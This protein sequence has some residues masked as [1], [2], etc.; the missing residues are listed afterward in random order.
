ME[1]GTMSAKMAFSSKSG[2]ASTS[3][4]FVSIRETIRTGTGFYLER[5]PPKNTIMVRTGAMFLEM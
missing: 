3:T 2:M 5:L 4:V 1:T